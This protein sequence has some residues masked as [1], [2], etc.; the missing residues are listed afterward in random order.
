MCITTK[1]LGRCVLNNINS[2]MRYP[3][4]MR[5]HGFIAGRSCVTNLIDTLDYVGSC[6][7]SGGHIYRRDLHG[8]VIDL[9]QRLIM[10]C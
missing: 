7:D 2:R 6:P 4:N 5:Q 3:V 10:V 8:Y 1:V 9:R